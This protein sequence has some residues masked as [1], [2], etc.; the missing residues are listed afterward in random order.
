LELQFI[1]KKTGERWSGEVKIPVEYL[2][3][4]VT[5]MN[6]FAIHGSGEGRQYEALYPATKE[7]DQPNL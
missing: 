2:P 5:L 3:P 4:N 1:A 7:F 6:A